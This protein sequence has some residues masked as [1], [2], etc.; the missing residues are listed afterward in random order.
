[1]SQSQPRDSDGG[2]V[3]KGAVEIVGHLG[4]RR[5]RFDGR[6]GRETRLFF[7]VHSEEH[8]W[9]LCTWDEPS[10]ELLPRLRGRTTLVKVS[11]RVFDRGDRL[12]CRVSS[13]LIA[14]HAAVQG[15]L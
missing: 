15:A 5:A 3:V 1:V 2:R 12:H 6:P 9:V 8:G 14:E 10:P 11:G 7:F 13:V 4:R